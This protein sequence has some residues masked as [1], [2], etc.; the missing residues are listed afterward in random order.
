MA[1]HRGSARRERTRPPLALWLPAA[2]GIVSRRTTLAERLP[3]NPTTHCALVAA[4][5][6]GA[7]LECAPGRGPAHNGGGSARKMGNTR[8]W[9]A[10]WESR[11]LLARQPVKADLAGHPKD[12]GTSFASGRAQVV[13][14][15]VGLRV[16]GRRASL[17]DGEARRW[18]TP[19]G[20][21]TAHDTPEFSLATPLGLW[22]LRLCS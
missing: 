17:R 10:P 16:G 20:Y 15:A 2:H 13:L 22:G 5:R 19:N 12:R 1:G 8:A 6:S 4:K 14:Q 18:P 21:L 7:A 9:R 11:Y 3:S